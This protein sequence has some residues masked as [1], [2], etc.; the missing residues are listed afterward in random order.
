M[1]P[2]QYPDVPG[3]AASI[4]QSMQTM[5]QKV[6]SIYDRVYDTSRLYPIVDEA[7]VLGILTR[8]GDVG[9]DRDGAIEFHNGK[10]IVSVKYSLAD[11]SDSAF[12][13]ANALNANTHL[14]PVHDVLSYTVVHVSPW[15][16]VGPQGNGIG[17]AMGDLN[18]LV[19]WLDPNKVQVI[20]LEQMIVDLRNNFGTPVQVPSLSWSGASSNSWSVGTTAN[21][22]LGSDSAVYY[23]GDA[24]RFGN[25]A[26]NR[27]ITIIGTVKP[28]SITVNNSFLNSYTIGGGVIG[29]ATRHRQARRWDAHS[30]W[31]QYFYRSRGHSGGHDR[32]DDIGQRRSC[33]RHRRLHQCRSEPGAGWRYAQVDWHHNHDDEPLIH[34]GPGRRNDRQLAG[35]QSGF[36][37]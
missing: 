3:L 21:W 25:G 19:Q 24:V 26:L 33:Q 5:D 10:P 37:L 32:H 35:R 30:D 36:D 18:Q 27:A 23:N 7:Q 11:G 34:A 13:I 29:G 6:T 1:Y 28:G 20:T 15:T 31:C 14:D 8:I 2:S 17:T 4:A 12:S 16:A 9:K 22:N